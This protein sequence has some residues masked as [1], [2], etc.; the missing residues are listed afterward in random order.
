[1]KGVVY[2]KHEGNVFAAGVGKVTP[3]TA[4]QSAADSSAKRSGTRNARSSIARVFGNVMKAK[5][6][7]SIS[8]EANRYRPEMV[9]QS[10]CA[11]GKLAGL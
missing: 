10:W 4:S 2:A 9:S 5:Q 11:A 1:M 6:Q 3:F 7:R 8:T